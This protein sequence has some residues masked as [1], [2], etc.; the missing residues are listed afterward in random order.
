MKRRRERESGYALLLVFVMASIVAIMLYMEIPR[1]AFESQREREEMLIDRGEEYRRAIQLFVRRFGT[2]PP[3]L[4]ALENTNNIRFLRRRYKDPMT[5]KEEWRLIH[6]GPGGV[7]IDSLTQKP[8]QQKTDSSG[9]PVADSSQA[10]SATSSSSSSGDGQPVQR[11][12]QLRPSETGTGQPGVI[13]AG[14]GT[15]DPNDP[16][17]PLPE[18]PPPD[19]AGAAGSTGATASTGPVGGMPPTLPGYSSPTPGTS[20]LTPTGAAGAAGPAGSNAAL[21]AIQRQLTTPS[22]MAGFSGGQTIG[23]GIAG[24]ATTLEA[25]GIKEYNKRTKYQEWE[26]I[27]DRRT[28][29]SAAP[30]LPAGLL[31]P[32]IQGGGILPANPR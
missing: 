17:V 11:W 26:F 31:Q 2:Y 8:P 9:F 5:G 15:P 1:V 21:A 4:E 24:V 7:M 23:G 13:G 19:A 14:A 10:S 27:Y 16:N 28:D 3:T 29:N 20:L 12:Q 32:G 6:A 25:E 18:T 30:S 22:P